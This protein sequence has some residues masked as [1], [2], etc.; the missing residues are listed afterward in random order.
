LR[1]P[2]LLS[3]GFMEYA[4]RYSESGPFAGEAPKS[5]VFVPLVVGDHVRGNISLQNVDREHAF[6][7]SDVR[8]LTTLANSMSVA[9]ENARLF[10]QTNK[11]LADADQRATE[12]AT[13]N[14]ISQAL[15]S[16]L[17]FDA[18]VRLVGDQ[19][20]QTFHADMAYV[21]FI[22]KDA[23]I[24]NFPYGYG[25]EFDPIEFGEG[26]T[27]QIIK[28][29]EALL[30]NED[31]GGRFEEL[32]LEEIGKRSASYLG[33]PISVGG[34]VVG[35][36]SVQSTQE[37]GR[38]DDDDLHLLSTIAANVGIALQNAE[39]YRQLNATLENLKSTQEQ[40][41]TQEKMASLGQLTAGIAHE[42]KNPLNFVNNFAELNAELAQEAGE[43]FDRH[44]SQIPDELAAD[45][46]PMLTGISVNAQQIHKHGKRADGIV[47]NMM[48][49]ATGASSERYRVEVNPLVDE[50]VGLAFHGAKAQIPDLD[51]TVTKDFDNAVGIANLAPQEIGRV[52][53]NLINNA[54]YAVHERA[55]HTNGAYTPTVTVST[56]KIADSIEIRVADNGKG[57]PDEIRDR[58][59]EPLFTTKPTGSGTGLGLSLSFDIVTQGHGGS[60]R[61]ESQAGQGAEFVVSIPIK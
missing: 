7:E 50:Y 4:N 21:A 33:V 57:I 32:G 58:I 29:G 1:E 34:A 28:N 43:M 22:D 2:L 15:V 18:L 56:R 45:L 16:Q 6:T 17:E 19:I 55:Q 42:I 39:A 60:L 11:L 40:L 9:L 36:V 52:L 20:Q 12:M 8:L 48:E 13:V 46:I 26:F 10:D 30:V 35:V 49:H 14:R 31:V 51:A 23:G 44:R 47:K 27:S 61:V 3:E 41:V 54:L 53:L 59:F 37:T 38:F 24:I 25:D 5:A